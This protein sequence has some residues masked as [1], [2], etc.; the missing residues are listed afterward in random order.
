[1]H[2]RIR[3]DGTASACRPPP[4]AAG[5]R[6]AQIARPV[7]IISSGR[8]TSSTSGFTAKTSCRAESG[9][10]MTAR[11]RSISRPGQSR[12]H[13][14]GANRGLPCQG[15][16][17]WVSP[18]PA[19]VCRGDRIPQPECLRDRRS[20]IAEQVLAA[21][22]PDAD[23][24]A[25]AGRIDHART[26]ATGYRLR[27]RARVPTCSGPG[28]GRLR[29]A[30]ESAGHSDWQGAELKMRD[31]DTIFVPKA[32]RVWVVGQVR[33]HGV[34]VYEEGMTVFEAIAAAGGITEKGS[35]SRI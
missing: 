29:H 21:G 20:A 33:I 15:A 23:G 30:G 19:G 1:M 2:E 32:E 26:R 5:A 11:F 4:A 13:D 14:D 12:G 8:R 3:A 17:R 28:I 34:I 6:R 16:R 24:R 9:S 18:H 25:D 35:N 27:T 10:T 31:G 22:K 7:P